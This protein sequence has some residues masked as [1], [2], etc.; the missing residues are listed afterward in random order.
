[1][2][3]LEWKHW[4]IH[5]QYS[6]QNFK[7]ISEVKFAL[8]IEKFVCSMISENFTKET[9]VFKCNVASK[10]QSNLWRSNRFGHWEICLR[11]WSMK[12]LT[13]ITL[14]YT[15]KFSKQELKKHLFWPLC[16]LPGVMMDQNFLYKHFYGNAVLSQ[17]FKVY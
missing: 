9:L 16:N 2:F 11:P 12:N 14:E 4:C 15:V 7:A 13:L 1:M 17:N 6:F 10:F 5:M 3:A 8:S